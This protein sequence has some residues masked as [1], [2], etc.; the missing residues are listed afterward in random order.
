MSY[1]VVDWM[2]SMCIVGVV[3]VVGNIG[4]MGRAMLEPPQTHK[5]V[6]DRTTEGGL[7]EHERAEMPAGD[8]ALLAALPELSLSVCGGVKGRRGEGGVSS[9]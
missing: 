4:C 8:N 1:S 2:G 6:D 9:R 7:V 5:R 3:V